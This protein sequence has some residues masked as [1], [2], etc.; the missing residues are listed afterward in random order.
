MAKRV[1]GREL[2]H[3]N[4]DDEEE[5]ETAGHF[6]KAN[7]RE[8]KGRVIKTARRRNPG[9]GGEKKNVFA[10]FGGFSAS[11]PA[12]S[13]SFSFLAK[14]GAAEP[15]KSESP[16][17]FGSV[18]KTD[19]PTPFLFGA[20]PAEPAKPSFGS[21]AFGKTSDETPKS[22]PFSSTENKTEP[23]NDLF[24]KFKA[25]SG[26]WS[27]DVCMISNPQEKVKCAACETLKPGAKQPESNG[28]KPSFGE[29]GGFKFGSSDSGTSSAVFGSSPGANA[30]GASSGGFGSVSGF[31]AGVPANSGFKFGETAPKDVKADVPKS[32]S[33]FSFGSVEKTSK[34]SP[35]SGFVFGGAPAAEK[36]SSSV[37][38]F[39]SNSS[40]K[41]SAVPAFGA[42]ESSA[43]SPSFSFGGSSTTPDSEPSKA[44]K[45][46]GFA[47]M[48]KSNDTTSAAKD[49]VTLNGKSSVFGA[50]VSA[51]ASTPMFGAVKAFSSDKAES[52]PANSSSKGGG[53]SKEYNED[54]LAHLKAL[55]L[56]VTEWIKRHIEEN[57]LVLLSPVF[58]DYEKH[59]KEISEKYP[60]KTPSKPKTAGT[61]SF[62]ISPSVRSPVKPSESIKPFSFAP[63]AATSTEQK[64]ESFKFGFGAGGS[65]NKQD[66]P[67]FSLGAKPAAGG[68]SF[69]SAPLQS[70]PPAAAAATTDEADEDAPPK[71]EVKQV[72]EDDA[73]YSRKCKLFYKKGEEYVDKGVGMLHLKSADNGR[74]QLLVRADTNLGNILLN[75]LLNPDI[76]TTRVGKNNVMLV[77]VPNPPI[78]AK[79]PSSVPL[80]M[81]IRVKTGDDADELKGKIDELKGKKQG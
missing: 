44:D 47:F 77:C 33:G 41:P 16:V 15:K 24:D 11:T 26:N 74:T 25:K 58:Q 56:Q 54:Y 13:D 14:P 34:E 64:S 81:L 45:P 30:F 4:W 48:S 55:N 73:L 6:K 46:A 20:S 9:E 40:P 19:S 53:D 61:T 27:C 60:P 79:N 43:K 5:S 38:A 66:P 59:L 1:A 2:N 52:T 10:G 51:K 3:Q 69:G 29:S 71:V 50:G 37:F 63:S 72:V 49:P 68:F 75:I 7:D 36:S 17:V 32:T 67:A 23:K 39:G 62:Q 65:E 76:P 18:A 80:P 21:F 22:S 57:P 70:A 78:D 42:T 28:V 8:M 35:A 31:A 12:A